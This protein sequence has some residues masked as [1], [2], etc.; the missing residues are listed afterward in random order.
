LAAKH[1]HKV[2]E[3]KKTV[4]AIQQNFPQSEWAK[5]ASVYTLL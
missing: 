2:E 4:K 5:R 1:T 3:L